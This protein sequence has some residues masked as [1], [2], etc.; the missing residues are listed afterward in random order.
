M[1]IDY[2][3]YIIFINILKRYYK[4][5]IIIFDNILRCFYKFI[6]ITIL[7]LLLLLLILLNY[8]YLIFCIF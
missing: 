7:L 1:T 5:I 8:S 2:Y 3:N 4:F 6:I